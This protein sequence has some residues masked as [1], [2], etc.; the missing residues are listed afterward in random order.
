MGRKR[1]ALN[2]QKAKNIKDLISK[3]DK[4]L[5][6]HN[7]W[8]NIRKGIEH[9][10]SLII[11]NK[12]LLKKLWKVEDV[13]KLPKV[14]FLMAS[15]KEIDAYIQK[16]RDENHDYYVVLYEG[17]ILV[18]YNYAGNVILKNFPQTINNPELYEK[19]RQSL[20]YYWI[21][22][23]LSHEFSH[24]FRKHLEIVNENKFMEFRK[25]K[26]SLL[27]SN[28]FNSKSIKFY[29]NSS[30]Y[31]ETDADRHAGI[32]YVGI[33]SKTLDKLAKETGIKYENLIIN[34]L[35]RGTIKFF[36][37]FMIL[38]K[39]ISNTH[40]C[41]LSRTVS[42]LSG[43]VEGIHNNPSI[44]NYDERKF[45][46]L[47]KFENLIHIIQISD[48]ENPEKLHMCI[49]ESLY[50]IDTYNLEIEKLLGRIKNE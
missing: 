48:F 3:A 19:L 9:I 34:L 37:M 25:R 29:I 43:C 24:L 18:S 44:L 8:E 4:E 12:A 40:P 45:V 6:R 32:I 49:Q 28:M 11:E 16:V 42:F 15:K 31:L 10:S 26:K 35:I 27:S 30:K 41:P 1:L 22:L 14:K 38:H 21:T 50:I 13:S 36:D 47:I 17:L 7:L 20:F 2:R 46:D 39:D 5:K 23:I 33:F